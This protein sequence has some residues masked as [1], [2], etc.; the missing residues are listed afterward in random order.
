MIESADI[1]RAEDSDSGSAVDMLDCGAAFCQCLRGVVSDQVFPEINILSELFAS[2][3]CEGEFCSAFSVSLLLLGVLYGRSFANFN[4]QQD[5]ALAERLKKSYLARFGTVRCAKENSES[6]DCLNERVLAL[7][8]VLN[9]AKDLGMKEW[10]ENLEAL[11]DK[12]CVHESIKM[13]AP[14]L[15]TDLDWEI[16]SKSGEDRIVDVSSYSAEVI[17]R[18]YRRGVL[19]KAS[20]SENPEYKLGFFPKRIDC[21]L[22][23]EFE[24]WKSLPED[25]KKSFVDY[26]QSFDVW[27]F[28]DLKAKTWEKTQIMPVEEVI[29]RIQETNNQ[30][31]IQECDCRT[32]AGHPCGN[33]TDTC[34]HWPDSQINTPFDRGYGRALTKEEAIANIKRSDECGLVHCYNEGGNVCNCCQDCCWAFSHLSEFEGTGYD[35]RF[36]F[37][38]V[39]RVISVD[40]ERCIGCGKCV[41]QC[42]FGALSLVN[43]VSCVDKDKCYGCGVCRCKCKDSALSLKDL[44]A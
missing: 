17:E 6:T 7:L 11:M 41:K 32:Y 16:V 26:M 9:I 36:D 12:F 39:T 5:R 3:T 35:P 28:P 25:A 19:N 4:Y 1:N 20:D 37:Y 44:V 43:G 33:P 18:E 13:Y 42:P 24:F 34:M 21:C 40:S 38:D 23:G 29:R 2:S 27:V 30:I 8:E 10:D 22:R 31:Y 14:L 15:M